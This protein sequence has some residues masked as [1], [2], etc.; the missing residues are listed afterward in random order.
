[1]V[2]VLSDTGWSFKM[3]RRRRP[4]PTYANNYNNFYGPARR[5][6]HLPIAN[7]PRLSKLSLIRVTPTSPLKRSEPIQD[8]RR[9]YPDSGVMRKEFRK[10]HIPPSTNRKALRLVIDPLGPLKQRPRFSLPRKV[11]V[12]VRRK[13]RKEVILATGSGGGNHR[14]P[15]RTEF[16]QVRC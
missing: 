5:G 7:R 12:C 15:K 9:Y 3:A 10:P 2:T 14:K 1:M 6:L 13:I 4:F 11:L 8:R 16:S